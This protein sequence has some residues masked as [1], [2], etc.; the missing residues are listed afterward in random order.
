MDIRTELRN[1]ISG[2]LATAAFPIA[3]REKLLQAFP[4]GPDTECRCGDVAMTAGQ[5]GALLTAADF[6]FM[7]AEA[8]ADTILDRAGLPA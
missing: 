6:P 2:A 5:A 1:Q 7:S 8:V 4:N 3:T